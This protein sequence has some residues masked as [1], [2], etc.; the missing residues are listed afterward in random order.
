M[1]RRA[2]WAA[3]HEVAKSRAQLGTHSTELI[4]N[5][6]L[7]PACCTARCISYTYVHSFRFFSYGGHY[8]ILRR[9]LCAIP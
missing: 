1:D 3:A 8:R 9:I 2:W 7:L 5:V 6:V 4:F